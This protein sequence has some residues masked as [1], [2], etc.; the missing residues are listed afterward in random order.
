MLSE[1]HTKQLETESGIFPETLEKSGIETATEGHAGIVFIYLDVETGEHFG[2]RIKLDKPTED[3]K[4]LSKEGAIPG[5]YFHPADLE[6]LNET[7]IPLL[8][9]EGE[10]KALKGH[11]ELKGYVSVGIPGCWGWSYNKELSPQW[12][13]VPLEEREVII[14][15]DTDYKTNPN[16]FE[17]LEAFIRQLLKQGATVRLL[18]LSI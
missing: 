6:D 9:A 8:I 15:P 14:C 18:D 10:K 3:A 16:V 7:C 5:I 2:T 1:D 12:Q 4:Y 17:G 11:Q 13:K